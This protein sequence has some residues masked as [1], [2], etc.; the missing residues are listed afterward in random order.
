MSKDINELVWPVAGYTDK[1]S[2]GIKFTFLRAPHLSF[3]VKQIRESLERGFPWLK[4]PNEH[5]LAVLNKLINLY[6]KRLIQDGVVKKV[7]SNVSVES[8]WMAASAVADSGMHNVT[9]ADHV[10]VTVAAKKGVSKRPVNARRLFEM[11]KAT[12]ST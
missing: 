3:T 7:K 4:N 5:Q 12:P 9:S 10:A 11:N 8:Q 1:I 2:S 6:T